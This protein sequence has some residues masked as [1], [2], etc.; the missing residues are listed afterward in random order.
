MR[1]LALA[2]ALGSA[3]LLALPAAAGGD[4]EGQ[5]R[6]TPK[7]KR[8]RS[9]EVLL[10]MHDALG[11]ERSEGGVLRIRKRVGLE[12]SHRFDQAGGDPALVFSIQGPVMPRK[13]LGLTFEIRF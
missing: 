8:P 4:G 10:D 11:V 1:L 5:A 2:A 6:R 12:Y 7:P 13:R 3:L 9:A